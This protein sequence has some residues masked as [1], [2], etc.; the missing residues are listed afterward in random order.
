VTG[1]GEGPAEGGAGERPPAGGAPIGFLGAMRQAVAGGTAFGRP[2]V[3]QG[4]AERLGLAEVAPAASTALS[5]PFEFLR[6]GDDRR[7]AA[8][9]A[10][11]IAGFG[12]RLFE[13]N[14]D[15][16]S[17][18]RG[19]ASGGWSTF[20]YHVAA[21][22]LGF[23]LPWLAICARRLH[24]PSQ[25]LY[26]GRRGHELGT[27]DRRTNRAYLL[28]ADD[29]GAA[30]AVLEGRMKDWLTGVLPSRVENRPVI[31]IEISGGWA[32]T[33]IQARGLAMPDAVALELP[34]QGRP[35][36]PGPWPDALLALLWSFR[37]LVPPGPRLAGPQR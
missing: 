23:Q 30:G 20:P 24:S 4:R 7:V 26:P 10:G 3:P 1:A 34:R 13:F 36:H 31:T 14:A 29:V 33:A 16:F 37:D 9:L 35:G 27:P 6:L 12:V 28:H 5:L 8:E 22:E 17:G 11:R 25:R 18:A 15:E 2:K 21:V 32:M 19:D